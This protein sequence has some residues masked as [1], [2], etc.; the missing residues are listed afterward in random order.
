VANKEGDSVAE[1]IGDRVRVEPVRVR[2]ARSFVALLNTLT[3]GAMCCP[4]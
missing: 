4:G 3:V 1:L 2:Q